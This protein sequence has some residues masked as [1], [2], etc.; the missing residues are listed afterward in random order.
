MKCPSC[1]RECPA[2]LRSPKFCVHCGHV[3]RA[4]CPYSAGDSQHAAPVVDADGGTPAHC[5]TCGRP[6]RVC[7]K[8]HR[9]ATITET[10]CAFCESPGLREAGPPAWPSDRGPLDGTREWEGLQAALRSGDAA[11][12]MNLPG[13][14][15]AMAYRHGYLVAATDGLLVTYIQESGKWAERSRRPCPADGVQ[16][17]AIEAGWVLVLSQHRARA[18]RLPDL[19]EG[20]SREGS[21]I[22]QSSSD[23][24][25]AFIDAG[26]AHIERVALLD[27]AE[28]LPP[29]P[30]PDHE[31][32]PTDIAWSEA[33]LAIATEG[34]LWYAPNRLDAWQWIQVP[35]DCMG[36]RRVGWS[37]QRLFAL[38]LTESGVTLTWMDVDSGSTSARSFAGSYL[39]DA[40]L[41]ASSIVLLTGNSIE[42]HPAEAPTQPCVQAGFA[43]AWRPDG[44]GCVRQ[45]DDGIEVLLP[46]RVGGHYR[47][48]CVRVPG[49]AGYRVG[50]TMSSR[51]V[52]CPAGDRLVVAAAEG[53]GTRIWTYVGG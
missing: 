32:T 43:G 7:A 46:V 26:R 6:Y 20:Y 23:G 49:G 13:V 22:I 42:V 31:A 24:E 39:P 48:Q 28:P 15:R 8:C 36:W 41:C 35:G 44:I 12:T 14:V 50:V 45:H 4:P 33:G 16:S 40:A 10:V 19:E 18:F 27:H 25:W 52:I 53:G 38:G 11:Q 51:P 30:S 37:G 5:I 29:S 21:P 9:L 1:Q 2:K 3:L 17:M 34:G 47:L